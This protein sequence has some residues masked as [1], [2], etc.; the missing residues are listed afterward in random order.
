M[1]EGH[2]EFSSIVLSY[3]SLN[4]PPLSARCRCASLKDGSASDT[5]ASLPMARQI[6]VEGK[7]ATIR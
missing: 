7:T 5:A 2:R 6:C 1:I 4:E 3:T